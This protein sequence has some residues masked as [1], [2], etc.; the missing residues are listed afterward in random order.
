MSIIYDALRKTQQN[1]D[2]PEQFNQH[3]KLM[4]IVISILL[5]VILGLLSIILLPYL[6]HFSKKPKPILHP[7]LNQVASVRQ[8]LPL[9]EVEYK[10]NL[11]L[12]GVFIA[13]HEKIALINNQS[14]HLG[15]LVDGK[16]IISITLDQVKMNDGRTTFTLRSIS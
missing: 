7:E 11:K 2:S 10:G 4:W 14:Y 9:K 3:N 1:F 13:D 12:T 5:I 6:A 8:I 15:D 16:K